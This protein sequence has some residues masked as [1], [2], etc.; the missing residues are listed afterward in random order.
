MTLRYKSKTSSARSTSLRSAEYLGP[1]L[2]HGG[3]LL[4]ARQGYDLAAQDFDEWHWCA[5]W[6]QNEAPLVKRWL[7]QLPPG[8][9]LDAGCGTGT[10]TESIT[11]MGHYYFAADLSASMLQILR[12]KHFVNT[13]STLV[14]AD[15]QNLPF[16]DSTFD[17]ILCTRVLSNISTPKQVLAELART[18]RPGGRALITDVHPKHPYVCTSIQAGT[19]SISIRTYKHSLE[20][21]TQMIEADGRFSIRTLREYRSGDLSWQPPSGPFE[22]L[23]RH[24]QTSV[25]YSF[26]LSRKKANR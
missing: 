15:L 23:F 9:G 25:F 24:S 10:Y 22:K 2:E 21:L 18:V 16:S 5:F 19:R 12:K 8:S 3:D 20:R 7:Q 6:Q 11:S 4:A 17:W 14:Q 1:A 13:A 26:D